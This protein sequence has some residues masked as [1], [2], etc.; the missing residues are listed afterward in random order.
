MFPLIE[1]RP[2]PHHLSSTRPPTCAPPPHPPR[3]AP[4][5]TPTDRKMTTGSLAVDSRTVIRPRNLAQKI[6]VATP[7]FLLAGLFS[8]FAALQRCLGLQHPHGWTLQ[9]ELLV[10]LMRTLLEYGEVQQY[11]QRWGVWHGGGL[12][13]DDRT[14]KEVAA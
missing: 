6:Y 7:L 5:F 1:T 3:G 8:L 11:I 10:T 12:C 13:A 2:V 9:E 14:C 4:P